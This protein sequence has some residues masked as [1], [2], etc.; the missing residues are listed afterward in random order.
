[1]RGG[2]T[3]ADLTLVVIK[4]VVNDDGSGLAAKDFRLALSVNGG[5]PTTFPGAAGPTGTTFT[6]HNG[7]TYTVTEDLTQQPL[8]DLSSSY[9]VSYSADCTVSPVCHPT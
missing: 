5:T 2:G 6:L 4:T 1:G 3:R 7:D 9:R 8:G